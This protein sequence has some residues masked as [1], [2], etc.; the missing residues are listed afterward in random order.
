LGTDFG[1]SSVERSGQAFPLPASRFT[2]TFVRLLGSEEPLRSL[3]LSVWEG[4][5]AVLFINWA[6]GMVMT[7]YALWLGASP[8]VLAVLGALPLFSQLAAPTALL[9]RGS[10][11]R[12]S[13]GLVIA[14]RSLFALIL[15]LPLLP[16]GWRIPFLLLVA[17]LSQM[18]L[19]PVNVLWTSWMAELIPDTERGRYFGFRN[20]VLGL[21]GTLGNLLGGV[22]IDALGK[23]W[24]FL[25]VLLIGVMAGVASGYLLKFQLEPKGQARETQNKGQEEY[26]AFPVPRPSSLI[27]DMR[28]AL[29]DRK[30]RVYLLFVAMF[31]GAVTVGSP[32]VIA[33]FLE[34]QKLSFS[35]VGLWTV[36]AATSGLFFGPFW[37][38]VADRVGH[39]PVLIWSG[40]VASIAMPGLWLSG[41]PDRLWPIWLSAPVDPIAWA[42]LGAALTN[43]TLHFAP[44]EKRSGYLAAFG[45]A[46]GVGGIVGSLVGG[47][48]GSIN[49]GPSPYH[50]PILISALLRT[51]AIVFLATRKNLR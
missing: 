49:I 8:A 23:P 19:A 32:F 6:T 15:L 2:I 35:D 29:G 4:A 37:G 42:G 43:Q 22:A 27:H 13:M 36:I 24:G 9:F 40:L 7:G 39:Y 18:M 20:G 34:Y 16:E 44:I 38:R 10:R 11:K 17:V 30:F 3:R 1:L 50:L 14:G 46:S 41:T 21:V 45:L 47:A 51:S 31:M 25:L 33:M 28:T 5:L 48:L 26:A 12:W